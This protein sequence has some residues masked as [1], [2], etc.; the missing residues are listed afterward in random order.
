M[1]VTMSP[2]AG[3]QWT[4]EQW[5]I[6]KVNPKNVKLRGETTGRLLNASPSYFNPTDSTVPQVPAT[7]VPPPD[8]VLGETVLIKSPFKGFDKDLI[9]VVIKTTHGGR[10][11]VAVL[12]GDNNQYWR[13]SPHNL[14]SVKVT[15]SVRKDAPV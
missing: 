12:G 8:F 9:W 1:R 6:T 14:I 5:I 3:A 11:N 13:T 15:A 2:H 10:V 7:Y 4:T